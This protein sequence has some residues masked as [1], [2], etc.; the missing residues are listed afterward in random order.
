MRTCLAA[1]FLY[2]FASASLFGQ[3]ASIVGTVVDESKAAL[4]GVAVLASDLATGR[5]FNSVSDERGEYRLVGMSPGRY[6]V[7]AE[8]FGFATSTIAGLALLVGQNENIV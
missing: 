2:V 7:Q 4:P 8:L 3:A 5:A 6:T 1:V